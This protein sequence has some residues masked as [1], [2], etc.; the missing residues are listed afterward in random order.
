MWRSLTLFALTT[1]G[2]LVMPLKQ[3]GG[4]PVRGCNML[5]DFGDV[6][7][8][9]VSESRG[10]GHRRLVLGCFLYADGGLFSRITAAADVVTNVVCEM[11]PDA[12]LISLC[13]PTEV[14]SVPREAA[15]EASRRFNSLTLH[16]PWER[17]VGMA[18]R[19]RYLEQNRAVP[20]HGI[21]LQDSLVWSQ[22]PNY[23]F[24]KQIQRWRNLVLRFRRGH[25]VSANV[26]PASLTESVMHNPLIKAGMLGC[27]HFG[28][29]AFEPRTSNS[30]M[31]ALAIHD[32]CEPSS[33]AHPSTR[34]DHPLDL[35]QENAV[36][37]G[38]FRCAYKTNSY[39]E[40]SAALYFLSQK[41][42]PVL[43]WGIAG[44][45]ALSYYRRSRL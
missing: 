4:S 8:W 7:A 24:S 23:A 43:E 22:G 35:F 36:H 16:T 11:C 14:F 27:S 17:A 9:I 18:S 19:G 26:A 21:L 44:A 37:G 32:I 29:L 41:I 28:I 33:S 3:V 34:L 38:T 31:T 25:V 10:R 39:T 2:T 42:V 6:A 13:S 40:V 30:L 12:C 5:S 20:A 45:T 15:R 1:P